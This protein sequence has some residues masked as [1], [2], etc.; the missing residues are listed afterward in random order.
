MLHLRA[1][2]EGERVLDVHAQIANGAL[3]LRV[4]E[5]DLHSA[6]VA[7]LLIDNGRLG[8]AQRMGPVIPSTQSDPGDPFVDQPSVLP[9]TD[10]I[11]VIDPTRKDEL[12]KRATSAFEPG[13][14]AAASG[15]KASVY[16]EF[17]LAMLKARVNAGLDRARSSG[18]ILG[19]PKVPTAV[20]DAIRAALSMG[21]GIRRVAADLGVGN[22]TVARIK[23]TMVAM[24]AA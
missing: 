24:K 4:A 10:M 6:Q 13:Q 3:D 16:A 11:G 12:V 19:R 22:S 8:S 20:E 17:E 15:L 9:G 18:K 21:K 23:A 2:S 1:L 14:H 7:R 5:Q